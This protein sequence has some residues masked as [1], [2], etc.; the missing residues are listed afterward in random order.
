MI[1]SS[2]VL[3]PIPSNNFKHDPVKALC[4]LCVNYFICFKRSL[5]Y[6]LILKNNIRNSQFLDIQTV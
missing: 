2:A 1:Y 4:A 3:F 6:A 5:L